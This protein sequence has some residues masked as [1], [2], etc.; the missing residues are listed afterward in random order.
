MI[1]ISEW[2]F[3]RPGLFPEFQGFAPA[4]VARFSSAQEKRQCDRGEK[5]DNR[6][7]QQAREECEKDCPHPAGDW[8]SGVFPRSHSVAKTSASPVLPLNAR[9]EF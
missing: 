4:L 8:Q 5:K 2:P 6:I 1:R 7:R 3:I 9:R